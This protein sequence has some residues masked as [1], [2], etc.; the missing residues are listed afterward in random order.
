MWLGCME[1]FVYLY[2]HKPTQSW[3]VGPYKYMCHDRMKR[4]RGRD[5][6]LERG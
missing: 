1:Y 6:L 4:A 3:S 2:A 5:G